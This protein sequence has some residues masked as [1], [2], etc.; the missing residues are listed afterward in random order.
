[1]EGLGILRS[2]SRPRVS[3]DNPYT[4]SMFRTA[5]YRPDYPRR[6]FANTEEG[7]LWV[8]SFV[9]WYNHHHRHRG[10]KFVTSQQRHSGK[11]LVSGLHRTVSTNRP[12]R[13]IR[14]A[15]P[16]PSVAG[17]KQEWSGSIHHPQK[18]N[19]CRLRLP[20]LPEGQQVHHHYW[21]L[22]QGEETTRT[23][24]RKEGKGRG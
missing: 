6:P 16:D 4:E 3:N 8:A 21:Q 5:K 15:G 12:A 24:K 2:F 7:C 13:A 22:P 10:I 18:T 9:D 1:L 11:A 23:S 14:A 20:W 19:R 17:F